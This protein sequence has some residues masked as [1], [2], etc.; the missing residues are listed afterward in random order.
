MSRSEQPPDLCGRS[1]IVSAARTLIELA[2]RS[3]YAMRVCSR[4]WQNALARLRAGKHLMLRRSWQ[5]GLQLEVAKRIVST[6]VI[7][8]RDCSWRL[9]VAKCI[10]KAERRE[11][12]GCRSYRRAIWEAGQSR[13][14]QL[15]GC[16]EKR[17]SW[18]KRCLSK[19]RSLSEEV[20]HK[21]K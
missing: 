8:L 17:S 5:A 7:F 10:V 1:P 16:S 18:E 2:W 12:L 21:E 9:E 13:S 15:S 3:C 20:A 4:L 19:K 11:D 6:I 14:S